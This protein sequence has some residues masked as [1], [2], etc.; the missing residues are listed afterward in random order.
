MI[1]LKERHVYPVPP[2]PL[3]PPA[4]CRLILIDFVLSLVS[5]DF[6]CVIKNG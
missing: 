6:L 4:Y 1:M 5:W 2:L 3:P